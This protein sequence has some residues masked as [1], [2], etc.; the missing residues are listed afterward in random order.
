M[1]EGFLKE[2]KQFFSK[3]YA[4]RA[5]SE[6]EQKFAVEKEYML[7]EIEKLEDELKYTKQI[8]KKNA[9]YFKDYKQEY[10]AKDKEII[11]MKKDLG[12]L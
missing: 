8:S 4:N 11:R 7:L 12:D 6:M 1:K 9:T 3:T 5:L 2:R 10:L